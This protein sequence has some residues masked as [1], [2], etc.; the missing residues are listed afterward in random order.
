VI[1][2]RWLCLQGLPMLRL[3]IAVVAAASTIAFTQIASAADLP[4]KAPVYAPP[5][6][7]PVS[8]WTGCYLNGGGGYGMYNQ[9]HQTTFDTTSPDQTNGGGGWFGTVGAGCDYQFNTFVV[10]ALVDYDFMDIHGNFSDT[11][12]QLVGAERQSSAWAV[13]ARV[14]YLVTP[15]ILMYIN[16]GWTATRFDS[17]TL[18]L[19]PPSTQ[20][21]LGAQTFNGGFIGGGTEVVVPGWPG[22]YWRNEYRFSSYQSANLP[23]TVDFIPGPQPM[24]HESKTVQMISTSLVWKFCWTPSVVSA[25]D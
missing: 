22:L 2:N 25:R 14:G 19:D 16:G 23:L 24:V 4:A 5:P 12:F 1:R 21:F 11:T 7:L 17:V 9:N 8:N 10:G 3:S 15:A 18:N 6:P 20:F 13:G